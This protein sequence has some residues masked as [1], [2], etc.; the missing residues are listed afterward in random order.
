MNNNNEWG[1]Y[2]LP[3]QADPEQRAITRL[4]IASEMALTNYGTPLVI[5]SSGGKDS[6]AIVELAIRAGI[7]FEVMH[8]HTTADAPETVRFVRTEFKR[9]EELGIKCT[10]IYPTYKGKRTSMWSLIPQK[11]LPPTRLVRYC[12][13][14]LKEHGGDGHFIATGVRWSES[15][16]RANSRGIFEK[17]VY[18]SKRAV[19]TKSDADSL[20]ALFAPCKL[21]AKH[22]VNPIVDWQDNDVWDFLNDAQVPVNPL[23]S[24]GF[25]RVG[26]I[27]CPLAGKKR[28]A[29]FRRY[30]TYEKLYLQAF[31]RMLKARRDMGR[32]TKWQTAEEVF[33]W[34]MGEDVVPG[35]MTWEDFA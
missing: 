2:T 24:C 28:Y 13:A 9:L 14:V 22:I 8:S 1:F 15:P 6:S 32:P 20:E 11:R 16:S 25:S 4:K 33:H 5:T 3:T 12:C 17:Q 30:P 29:E 27:G 34:W 7:P 18:D 21:T 10:I 23:Y 31:D 26:C 35:Q 19:H